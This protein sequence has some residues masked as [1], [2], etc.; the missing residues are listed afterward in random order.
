[1]TIYLNKQ[2]RENP[3]NPHKYWGFRGNKSGKSACFDRHIISEIDISIPYV[4]IIIGPERGAKD[5]D[6]KKEENDITYLMIYKNK[7]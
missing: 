7:C 4:I 6:D 3:K 1:M 2:K 5:M